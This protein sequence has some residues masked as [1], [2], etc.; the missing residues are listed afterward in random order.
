MD[1]LVNSLD[2]AVSE[3]EVQV[4]ASIVTHSVFSSAWNFLRTFWIRVLAISAIL[5]TPCLWHQYIEAGDLASHEY[6]AW[7]A[8]LIQTGHAPGLYL[9]RQWNN[10]L[11]DFALSAAGNLFSLH[12]AEKLVASAAVLIFFWGAFA[13]VSAMVGKVS[14]PVCIGIAI[15]A[16][17]WTFEIGFM[18]YYLSVGLAFFGLAIVTS[19]RGWERCFAVILFPLIWL[20]HPLGAMLLAG[21]ATYIIVAGYLSPKHQVLMCALAAFS[22][23]VAHYFLAWRVHHGVWADGHYGINWRSGPW[24]LLDGFDQLVVYGRQ[25]LVPSYFFRILVLISIA[26]EVVRRRNMPR[27]WSS[28]LLPAQLYCLTV[29]AA[30]QLPTGVRFPRYGAPLELLTERLTLVSAVLICCLIAAARPRKWFTFCV[31]II[32]AVYFFQ[33]YKD[34]AT[35]NRMENQIAALVH[36]LPP[37]DRVLATFR[38]LPGARTSLVHM[39]D[40]ACIGQCFTYENYEPSSRQFRVRAGEENNIV[41]FDRIDVREA[42]GGK[43]VVKQRDLPLFE[44]F[45]CDSS[46][47]A[48]CMRELTA[49][50]MNGPIEV[51]PR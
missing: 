21:A 8:H 27:W 10:V 34:T 32:A 50:E 30:T 1:G 51:P 26:V 16:Y 31:A 7:L 3:P 38:M 28:F 24:I 5:L 29:L 46:L 41:M 37:G 4:R 48:L 12:V 25:Y 35:Y 44:I 33:I 47:T 18:N 6:N 11:F 22:L 45:Q 13:F 17:G 19:G 20:A 36:T 14:W 2:S 43:Y 23:L 39:V 49:G 40:R 42:E 15:F 9:V